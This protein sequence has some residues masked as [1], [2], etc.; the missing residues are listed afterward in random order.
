MKGFV[1]MSTHMKKL[2]K[3]LATKYRKYSTRAEAF[4]RILNNAPEGE[5]IPLIQQF[6][7]RYGTVE[8]VGESVEDVVIPSDVWQNQTNLLHSKVFAFIQDVRKNNLN[9]SVVASN[10]LVLISSEPEQRVVL[11][12]MLIK[13]LFPYVRIPEEIFLAAQ[14]MKGSLEGMGDCIISP[15]MLNIVRHP[16]M[17]SSEKVSALLHVVLT[18]NPDEQM[19][20][21]LSATGCLMAI[22][23][24]AILSITRIIKT[25]VASD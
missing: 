17:G 21:F 7:T 19:K 25:E 5:R 20:N 15:L 3:L 8:E 4:L 11:M 16:D 6:M 23:G 24:S 13:D 22:A 14:E 18:S 9:E 10:M 2:E 1:K 12:G